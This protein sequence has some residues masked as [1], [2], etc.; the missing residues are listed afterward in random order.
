MDVDFGLEYACR[1]D[2][3]YYSFCFIRFVCVLVQSASGMCYRNVK[4]NFLEDAF[5]PEPR[6]L[7]RKVFE[8]LHVNR[9]V[10][11]KCLDGQLQNLSDP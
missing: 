2:L 4:S 11:C 8:A 3:I 1:I 9:V 7:T 10:L 5:E 6:H